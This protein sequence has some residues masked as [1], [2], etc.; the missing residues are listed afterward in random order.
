MGRGYNP[1]MSIHQDKYIDRIKELNKNSNSVVIAIFTF[2]LATLFDP[3]DLLGFKLPLFLAC[4]V[5]TFFVLFSRPDKIK[6]PPK[7]IAYVLLMLFVPL[8]SMFVYQVVDGSDP[9]NGFSMYKAYIFISFSLL[10]YINRINI[11]ANLSFALNIVAIII[12]LLTIVMHFQPLLSEPIYMLG[13]KM[14]MFYL[15]NR[16]Y[17]GGLTLSQV[18]FAVSPMLVISIAHYFYLSKFSNK[19]KEW[20]KLITLIQIVAMFMAGSRNNMMAA[21]LLPLSLHILFARRRLL[22]IISTALIVFL[23]VLFFFDELFILLNPL[24]HSNSA[25]IALIDDYLTM[26]TDTT[27]LIFGQGLGSYYVWEAYGNHAHYVTELSYF[28]IIRNFGLFFGVIMLLMLFYPIVSAFFINKYYMEK[29]II[30]AYFFY[31]IMCISN[32]NLFS[33]M[34]M[35]ILSM[36]MANMFLLRNFHERKD[37]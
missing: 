31:L 13:I 9:F 35:L 11:V 21:F 17:G 10:L 20:Y 5:T 23:A 19:H 8:Y 16:N 22:S 30:I 36:I 28:E 3:A 12:I 6:L 34:G 4:W 18:Y 29:H 1:I 32:P 24:E 27:T 37:A 26:F 25:K 33:S 14:K 15:D 7:L 2:I